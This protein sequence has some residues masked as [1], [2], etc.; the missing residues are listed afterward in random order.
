MPNR[1][2]GSV[3]GRWDLHFHTPSSYD[4]LDKSITNEQIIDNLVKNE[5]VAVAIT[6]HHFM[7][8]QRIKDLSYLGRGRVTVFP[9]IELRSE[10][11]GRESV[12]LIGVFKDGADPEYLWNKLQGPLGITPQEI[13][14]KGN[15]EVYVRFEK[16]AALIHEL[17]GYVSVHV[18]RKSNSIENIG[19]D[20]PYKMAFKR[21]LARNHIDIFEV[22]RVADVRAYEEKVFP[23]IDMR[24]PIIICSDNHKATD[25]KAKE[26]CWIKGDPCFETL[27]QVV[28]DPL[29]RVFIGSIPA[30]LDRVEHNKTKYIASLDFKKKTAELSEDWF[31]GTV[32]LNPGLV[33]IIGNKGSGKTAL[34]ETLGLLGNTAQSDGFSFLHTEKFRQPKNNKAK[35]FT[36]TLNWCDGKTHSAC[37]DDAVGQNLIE[38][39][40]Y[41]PQNYLEK[42]CNELRVS[43]S[44]FDKELKAVIFSHVSE[45][46]RIGVKT[47]DEL[48]KF[49]TEPL[50]SWIDR[51]RTELSQTNEKIV[52]LQADLSES[53]SEQ[54]QN[55][56][57]G[58][59]REVNA[60]FQTKPA[61]VKAEADDPAQS[62]MLEA[63]RKEIAAI[64][65]EIEAF[66]KQ[67]RDQ[68]TIRKEALHK[69]AVS[70]R[71]ISKLQ[72][73]KSTYETLIRDIEEECRSINLD[74]RALIQVTVD[75]E[76]AAKRFS[77]FQIIA[78][79]SQRAITDAVTK[80]AEKRRKIEEL[81]ANL[82]LP[83]QQ[84]QAYR[85]ALK[86]WEDKLVSLKGDENTSDSLVWLGKQIEDRKQLPARLAEIEQNRREKAREIYRKIAEVVQTY[87]YFYRPVQ[88]FVAT[89]SLASGRFTVDFEASVICSSLE[90]LFLDKINQG[91]KGS[92]SGID[93]GRTVLN[94]LVSTGDF[95]SENGAVAFAEALL[96]HVS[97][98]RREAQAPRIEVGDQLKKGVTEKE[99]LD[100]IFSFRY[101]VPKYS[102][103]WSGKNL[104]ELSP[105]E[106]GTLLLI[107]YLLVDKRDTPL[108]LDQPEE[109]LDNRTVYDILVP[110]IKEARTRRQVII[111]THNP[112]L[113]V[114][115]DA[116]Q[117]IHCHIDKTSRNKV[118][119]E[120]GAL[121]SAVL[122]K[123][124]MDVLEGTRPAFH[125]R[126]SKYHRS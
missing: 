81:T 125:H 92:F 106:R 65:I 26:S 96:D 59:E 124:S 109:N 7:D 114:V 56:F 47:L 55:L 112:N 13:Q 116:D 98:D 62:E 66:T 23:S 105:G 28:S 36:A 63:T 51:L 101:L 50:L 25:Y 69:Q 118:T 58:K 22:S 122:N 79:D 75:Q 73:F 83:N 61:E 123:F 76:T 10:L 40:S 97:S 29:D 104:E 37:L 60:H 87:E 24:L 52:A 115:C 14:T 111:V 67:E 93:E 27:Q 120:T 45:G 33:A 88:E 71:V 108:I 110:C 5:I 102:L 17:G 41:I 82:D 18:G 11:G 32:H 43:G 119:Y 77:E 95:S 72:N 6:D 103:K 90:E 8:V 99:I 53:A 121:E 21:D 4:Y 3:W 38:L 49:R 35:H 89:H 9:A 80:R 64:E 70:Q 57:D 94:R 42:I 107:F 78:G 54:L 113:A 19:N 117:I 12:H 86:Q 30:I 2:Q 68:E 85:V 1:P 100:T 44:P 15:D 74:A 46:D 39:I 48:L 126:D 34:A 16:A 91:R 31:A 20:H 84:F